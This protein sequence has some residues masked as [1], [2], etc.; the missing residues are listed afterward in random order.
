MRANKLGGNKTVYIFVKYIFGTTYQSVITVLT[1]WAIVPSSKFIA[2]FLIPFLQIYILNNCLHLCIDSL[3][4]TTK[5][6]FFMRIIKCLNNL[7]TLF[8]LKQASLSG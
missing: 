1:N 3:A 2:T 7:Y 4:S 8:S 6:C 5:Q